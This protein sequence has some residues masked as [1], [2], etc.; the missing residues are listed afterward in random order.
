MSEKQERLACI[1][2]DGIFMNSTGDRKKTILV[3]DDEP[4]LSLNPGQVFSKDQLYEKVRG[5]DGNA[6]SSIVMEHIRRI[7][8]KIGK[9]T[10]QP[11]IETVW[12]VG[13]RGNL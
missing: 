3:A 6:D 10:S 1:L 2:P 4:V 8:G 13:Y 12:G 5:F 7:R 11:Y 9:Y